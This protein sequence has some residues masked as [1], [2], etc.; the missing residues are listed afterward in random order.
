MEPKVEIIRMYTGRKGK[1]LAFFN[2]RITI[3]Q[4]EKDPSVTLPNLKIVEGEKG[5]FIG[6]PDRKFK[7]EGFVHLYFPNKALLEIIKPAALASYQKA[8]EGKG[9]AKPTKAGK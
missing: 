7:D 2:A 6:V 1:V 9:K 8:L 4:G 5:P 3:G